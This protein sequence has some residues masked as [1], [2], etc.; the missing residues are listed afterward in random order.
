MTKSMTLSAIASA[1]IL[2]GCV[3]QQKYDES[4]QRN[5]ELEAQ[6]QQLN[7]A[8]GNEISSRDM[9][10]SR[11]QNAIKV[12]LNDQLLFPSGGW[13]ISTGAKTSIAK[14]AAILAP[15][16]KNKID[17][18]G[19]TD[20]TPIGPGLAKQGITSN[21]I[22]SQKRADNVMQYMISQGV[23][24]DLVSAKGFGESNP[25]ASND[26]PEG[27]AQNRRV[28]LTIATHGN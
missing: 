25:I 19:Y 9:S 8:M 18:N 15:H 16:Q 3:S 12:S 24:P 7:T 1:L 11:M 2:V 27:K 21:Q 22:L 10:I 5:A 6:Y 23:K 4:Q 28:E 17:V 20:S 13:E 26:T 14:I